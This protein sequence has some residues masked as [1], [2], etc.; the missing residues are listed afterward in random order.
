MSIQLLGCQDYLK[1]EQGAVIFVTHD[2]YFLD[3][4]ST[5]IY[6]LADK[7]LYSHTGNYGDY[8]ESKAFVKKWLHQRTINY[9]IDTVQN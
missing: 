1:N 3:A 9:E 4:V 7:T 8:L 2:R 5:H 6:E